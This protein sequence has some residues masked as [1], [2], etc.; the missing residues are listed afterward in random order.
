M[1]QKVDKIKV[2]PGLDHRLLWIHKRIQQCID[3]ILLIIP[4]HSHGLL[5]HSTLIR[6]SRRLIVMRIRNKSST[7]AKQRKRLNLQVSRFTIHKKT[8]KFDIYL[9]F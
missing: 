5:A 8:Y 6:I 9:I 2:Y 7:D 3:A 4:A 1:V